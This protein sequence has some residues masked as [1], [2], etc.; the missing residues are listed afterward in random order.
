MYAIDNRF[1]RDEKKVRSAIQ[2]GILVGIYNGLLMVECC[3][4]GN[5]YSMDAYLERSY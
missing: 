4:L 5:R 3:N 1:Y 2:A